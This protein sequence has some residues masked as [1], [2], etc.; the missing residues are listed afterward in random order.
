VCSWCMSLSDA[1]MHGRTW[2]SLGETRPCQHKGCLYMAGP[3]K[4][5]GGASTRAGKIE[6]LERVRALLQ[7]ADAVLSTSMAGVT[8]EQ[9]DL[10]RQWL[11]EE[12]KATVIKNSLLRLSSKETVFEAMNPMLKEE[13][14][15]LFPPVGAVRQTFEAFQR[16]QRET[17]RTDPQ[18][19][20]R[21]IARDHALFSESRK[22]E[23]IAK[24]PTKLE[25]L[26]K[27][28]YMI[29][30]LPTRIAIDIKHIPLQ[31]GYALVAIKNQKE[32]EEKKLTE[33]AIPE[34]MP[35]A[36]S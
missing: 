31:V 14:L 23:E 18:Y 6:V 22:I 9:I 8:V 2:T 32:E 13:S 28:A 5:P 16:W 26:T 11:P 27:L 7:K 19:A 20:L 35:S 15:F 29:K 24:L 21:F 10:L 12:T 36:A 30:S 3:R 1:F 33:V 17:K 34:L 4:A 25:V